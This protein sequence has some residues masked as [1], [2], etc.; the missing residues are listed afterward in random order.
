MKMK[1]ID[2]TP[3]TLAI[4]CR[5]KIEAVGR[6]GARVLAARANGKAMA[7]VTVQIPSMN[8]QQNSVKVIWKYALMSWRIV[9]IWPYIL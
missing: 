2:K 6:E 4:V 1:L 8:T 3:S 7:K 5:P 9:S